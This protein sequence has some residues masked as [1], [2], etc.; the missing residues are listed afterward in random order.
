MRCAQLELRRCTKK[1]AF[2]PCAKL[3]AARCQ[4][5]LVT[6]IYDHWTLATSSVTKR[7]S[8]PNSKFNWLNWLRCGTQWWCGTRCCL[9]EW[10]V[11]HCLT[12]YCSCSW[13]EV[14]ASSLSTTTPQPCVT[15]APPTCGE[16]VTRAT[17]VTVSIG[18]QGYQCDSE[19]RLPGLP[20]WQ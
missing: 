8:A 18:Y 6:Y 19:Y 1:D 10:L 4:G 3:T 17:S 15:T 16:S 20:V 14:T 11:K 12:V 9:C 5:C 2:Q 13:F 7:S